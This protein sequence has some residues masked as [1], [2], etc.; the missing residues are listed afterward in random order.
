VDHAAEPQEPAWA[1]ADD[2]AF[3]ADFLPTIPGFLDGYAAARTMD[4]LAFQE[5]TGIGGSLLEIGVFYGRYL[6]V[7]LRSAVRT[8]DPIVALDTFEVV[9][10]PVVE[11]M[12]R[13]LDSGRVKYVQRSSRMTTASELR[14]I[15]GVR[16]RFVSIDGSHAA[17]DAFW[18]LCLAEQVVAAQGVVALDDFLNPMTP[19]VNEAAHRFFA[20]SRT[21]VPFAYTANKLFLC[22]TE[23]FATYRDV[24][25]QAVIAD[26][27]DPRSDIFRAC[28]PELRASVE[29]TLWGRPLWIVP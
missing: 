8:R 26:R 18:D 27:T 5:R 14:E 19:G 20:E 12:L 10:A 3:L 11:L 17:E 25:E 4:L 29:Q 24:F 6:S 21:L 1:R 23:G 7:L 2:G 9:G 22:T 15:L 28:L 13:P 16:A